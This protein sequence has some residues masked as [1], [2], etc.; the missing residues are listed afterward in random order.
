[1]SMILNSCLVVKFTSQVLEVRFDFFFMD[2]VL[3]FD[4]NKGPVFLHADNVSSSTY[5][6]QRDRWR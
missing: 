4:D 3:K 2:P 5:C 6:D 1:M